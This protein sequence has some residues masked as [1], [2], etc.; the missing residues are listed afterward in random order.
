LDK[1]CPSKAKYCGKVIFPSSVRIRCRAASKPGGAAAP[2]CHHTVV[3]AQYNGLQRLM[4]RV[5]CLII[6]ACNGA[7][8]FSG[9]KGMPVP[10]RPVEI[11]VTNRIINLKN[12][13]AFIFI[14]LHIQLYG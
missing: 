1:Y 2:P 12:L 11:G 10:K 9:G 14:S 4:Q 13:F 8:A 7:T 6:K 5:K 3:T